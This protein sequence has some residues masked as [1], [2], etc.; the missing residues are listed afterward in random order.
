MEIFKL[1]QHTWFLEKFNLDYETTTKGMGLA[2][3]KT[4]KYQFLE[5]PLR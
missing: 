1:K 4:K 3:A 2:I 5:P